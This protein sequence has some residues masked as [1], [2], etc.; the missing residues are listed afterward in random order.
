LKFDFNREREKNERDIKKERKKARGRLFH[1]M[2]NDHKLKNIILFLKNLKRKR[3]RK[4][5][6]LKVEVE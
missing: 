4:Y 3:R 1:V 2:L 5:Y 6:Q